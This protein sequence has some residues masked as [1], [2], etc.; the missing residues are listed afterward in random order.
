[1]LFD[2]GM[3]QAALSPDG[4]KVLFTRGQ[5]SWWRKGFRGPAAPQPKARRRRGLVGRP[6]AT[7]PLKRKTPSMRQPG[8][9]G[10]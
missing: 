6:P 1:M 5:A 8:R 9:G 3:D 4:T 2:A 7:R 10:S